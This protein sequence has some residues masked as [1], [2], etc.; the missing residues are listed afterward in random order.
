MLAW[1]HDDL[2]GGLGH[3]DTDEKILGQ[4]FASLWRGASSAW[5]DLADAGCWPRK[6]FEL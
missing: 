4:D 2:Q 6:L 5:L 3:V 1:Q